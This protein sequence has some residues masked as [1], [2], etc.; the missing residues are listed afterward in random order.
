MAK[1]LVFWKS[2]GIL[3]SSQ[4]SWMLYKRKGVSGIYFINKSL[5]PGAWF[6]SK[7]WLFRWWACP[8]YV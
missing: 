3:R 2:K 1:L 8:F 5:Y 4:C 7:K 6:L